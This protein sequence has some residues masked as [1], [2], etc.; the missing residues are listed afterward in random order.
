MILLLGSL[1][2]L[3]KSV[4]PAPV[5]GILPLDDKGIFLCYHCAYQRHITQRQGNDS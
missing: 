4:P 3:R 1:D 5:T 2:G